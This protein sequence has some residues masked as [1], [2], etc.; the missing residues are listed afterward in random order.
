MPPPLMFQGDKDFKTSGISFIHILFAEILSQYCGFL[1]QVGHMERA[2]ATYQAM[3]EFTMFCP[4]KYGAESLEDRVALFESFWDSG[5][6]RV[7][8]EGARGW[9]FWIE[10]TSEEPI[11]KQSNE[12]MVQWCSQGGRGGAR[13]W[14]FWVENTSVEPIAKHSNEGMIQWCSH[15][16]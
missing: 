13:G 10:N 5:V 14:R 7:G 2:V 12:G 3:A 6:A 16:E 11:A 8:E 4:D 9:R 1:Q 15:K